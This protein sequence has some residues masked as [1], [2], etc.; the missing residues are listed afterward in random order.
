MG[1]MLAWHA[2]NPVSIPGGGIHSNY[3][4][5]YNGTPVS[6]EPHW[7]V[8][9]TLETLI[10]GHLMVIIIGQKHCPSMTLRG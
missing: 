3:N 5:H 2:V 1:N 7:H 6:L 8:K 4:D 10:K 9:R